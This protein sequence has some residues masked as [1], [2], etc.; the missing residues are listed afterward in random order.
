MPPPK[1]RK[2]QPAPLP[3]ELPATSGGVLDWRHGHWSDVRAQCR[4]CP[5]MTNLRDTHGR[6]AHKVC[7]EDAAHW[8]TE[9]QNDRHENERTRG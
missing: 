8:W 1:R 4:Y 5:Q 6:P 9:A 2:S 7:A 3:P